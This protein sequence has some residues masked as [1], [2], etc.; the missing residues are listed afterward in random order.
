MPETSDP[1]GQVP[2]GYYPRPLEGAE[3][4]LLFVQ[5]QYLLHTREGNVDRVK[6]LAPASVRQAFTLERIDSGWLPEG[7]CR[8]GTGPAGDWMLAYHKPQVY[9]IQVEMKENRPP[10][11]LKVPLPALAFFGC[12]DNYYLWALR[13]VSLEPKAQLYRAPLPNINE[14]GLI[15]FGS[16]QRPRVSAAS[17]AEAWRLFLA[18]PF[19]DHHADGLSREFPEDVRRQLAKL[20]RERAKRYPARDL[21]RIDNTL[22]G[23]VDR[24]TNRHR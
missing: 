15:C 12:D 23:A 2:L 20:Y 8:W 18:A 4:A 3:A 5:G 11:R 9:E 1:N 14:H 17:F 10:R 19:N 13:G 7:V 21:V 22:E 16:N 24:L 6:F